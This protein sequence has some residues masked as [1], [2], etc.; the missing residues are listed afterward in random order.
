MLVVEYGKVYVSMF[1]GEAFMLASLIRVLWSNLM[2][3]L[4]S[5]PAKSI[6]R[7]TASTCWATPLNSPPLLTFSPIK[8]ILQLRI[9]NFVITLALGYM[10]QLVSLRWVKTGKALRRKKHDHPFIFSGTSFDFKVTIA[11]LNL[12]DFMGVKNTAI[13]RAPEAWLGPASTTIMEAWG[14]Q[15]WEREPKL[16]L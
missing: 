4:R 5:N 15:T 10:F 6:A 1:V 9:W 2:A 13:T 3:N 16:F 7:S 12:V 14:S 11:R 8:Y